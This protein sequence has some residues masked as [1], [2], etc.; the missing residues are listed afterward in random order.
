MRS[1]PE[2][3]DLCAFHCQIVSPAVAPSATRL[4][5]GTSCDTH[6]ARA[7]QADQQHERRAAEQRDQRRQP[8]EVDV[9]AFEVGGGE[10]ERVHCEVPSAVVPPVETGALLLASPP[11]RFDDGSQR[12]VRR[13]DGRLD[14]PFAAM[15]RQLRVQRH[16][17]DHGQQRH[18]H[19]AVAEAELA[20]STFGP[21]RLCIARMNSRSAYTLAN[22]TPVKAMIAIASFVLNTPS[23][24]RNSP[25][26]FDEPGIASVA[27]RDDQEDRREHRR[28]EGD[29]A[30]VADV[31]RAA[32]ALC[33]QRRR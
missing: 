20:D 28:A 7:N 27:K 22:T 13:G 23:R 18:E 26:K 25:T 15:Q 3:I 12:V 4:S 24:I 6:P 14:R 16:E 33:E 9:R 2:T 1:A 31:L 8:R 29:A 19:E 21:T 17:H 10:R 11:A 32:R 5:A 30:H